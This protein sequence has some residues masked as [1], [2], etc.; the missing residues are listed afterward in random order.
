MND[1]N[2]GQY[3]NTDREL[4]REIEG[5]Y[6]APSIFV[7]E[8][9]AIGI[10]VAGHCIIKSLK[11]WHKQSTDYQKKISRYSIEKVAK[12]I[13]KSRWPMLKEPSWA[14][15]CGTFCDR[16]AKAAIEVIGDADV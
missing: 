4:W 13:Y 3:Q 12:A 11:A 14:D 15:I 7:T 9:G 1:I 16:D 5:D 6:Y 2:S 8:S 10:N